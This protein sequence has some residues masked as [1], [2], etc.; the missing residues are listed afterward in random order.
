MKSFFNILTVLIFV[1]S[2]S[3][4][5]QGDTLK[6]QSDTTD[7][8][9]SFQEE[10][11]LEGQLTDEDNS[12]NLDYLEN[13]RRNPYDLNTVTL[14]DLESVP[15]LNKI[16]A[17]NILDYKKEVKSFK[18]KRE[19]LKVSGVTED[20][21]D[22]I[23]IYLIVR[24]ST[25]DVIIDETGNKLNV[26]KIVNFLS[27]STRIRSRF[28]QDLQVREG[29]NNGNYTGT[30]PK[31]Y[32]QINSKYIKKDFSLEANLTVEKDAGEKNYSDFVSGFLE[33]KD[34]KFIKNAVA[35]DYSLNFAQGLALW[36][37]LSF[38]KGIDAVSPL[39]K[40]GKGIDGY[41]S[42]N[43]VQFFRGGA[44]KLNYNDFNL[45]LFY[46]DNYFDAS[47]DTTDG[48]VS[49]FYYDGY[50]RTS[51]EIDRKNASKEK[52]FGGRV[53]YEK[54]SLKLG[55][56]YWSS[57]F[58]KSI[59]PDSLKQLFNFSGTEAN[60]LGFDYDFIFKNMNFYGE[61]ARSQSKAVASYNALQITFFRFA[62]VLLSYRNYPYD[63]APIH[64]FGFGERNGNTINE[65]GFYAGITLK[66]FKGLYI[67]S[68][69]DQF[70]FPY[71][72]YFDPVPVTGNDFLTAVEWR[73]ARGLVFNLKYKNENKE[74]SRTV[75]D[76]FGRD[77][78]RI[79][80]RNQIN[81]R[82]GLIYEITDRFRV[83]SRFEYVNVDYKNYGGD[84]KGTM[85]FSDV[86]I[87]PV[88]GFVFDMRYIIFDT[89]DYDSRI[90][91]FENDIRGVMS[92]IALYGKGRR[93]YMVLR[94]KPLPFFEISGKYAET[95]IDGVQSIGSGNDEINNDINN[96]LSLGAEII[97]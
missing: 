39:K 42:V 96:R 28:I 41:S 45:N 7:F 58:S 11:L 8:R 53:S 81:G 35:G 86:R 64:S 94:Y 60:M 82:I 79:D 83:R 51:S 24:R 30:K 46:S 38:S 1:Y 76:E 21:Y 25:G 29:Y 77:V 4:Y 52:L 95:Y 56:T 32:N 40:R 65:R 13:L 34:Y 20:V 23:K 87:I 80:N 2:G 43:E 5:S 91:E 47:L 49:S 71:R 69:Y 54:G 31:L 89:D 84:N 27:F 18:S 3:L 61:F 17:K 62:D 93:W 85:F 57:T 33:L 48:E 59:I 75:S 26:S 88:T 16:I 15:F 70:K 9:N 55:S 74:E 78:K 72:T 97:F 50:H 14:D 67:N 22:K 6:Q 36:S 37:S 68:Y 73:A 66:P 44:T 19:L 10:I 12:N 63:F 92:N 90:Y